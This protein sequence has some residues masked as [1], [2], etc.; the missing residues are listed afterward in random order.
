MKTLEKPGKYD[1]QKMQSINVNQINNLFIAYHKIIII[2]EEIH[3]EHLPFGFP[4]VGWKFFLQVQRFEYL[5]ICDR[6]ISTS[7]EKRRYKYL[8]IPVI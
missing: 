8:K 7:V 2:A 3:F 6:V 1:E 5:P 4:K